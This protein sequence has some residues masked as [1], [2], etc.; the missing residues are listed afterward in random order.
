MYAIVEI[1]GQQFKVAKDQKVY[2][3]RLQ[4]EEGSK[5]TFDNVLLLEDGSNITIGA[6]AIDGAAVEAKVIKHLKGDKVIVFKKKRRK[7][8]K[9]KNGHRQ[10]LT[11]LVIESIVSSGAKKAEKKAEPKKEAVKAA[12]KKAAAKATDKADDLKKVEGI[13][14]KIAETLVA[15]GIST[16]A[17]LAKTDAAKIS[18]I[19]ADVRGNHVTDTWPAQAKLAAEGKW[20]EL[21]KWQDELDGGK[22]A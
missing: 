22:P 6:P 17:E 19:I 3:H 12:P 7:G 16:F 9:V 13:G 2:V 18:E 14:P 4:N 8:Y 20:D 10:Y 5:V 1:A 11:E 21:K 15:A